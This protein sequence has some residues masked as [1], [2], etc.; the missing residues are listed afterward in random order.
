[1]PLPATAD[2]QLLHR[3]TVICRGYERADGQIEIDAVITDIKTE[4]SGVAERKVPAGE[5]VHAMAL[6][7]TIGEGLI[8]SDA[9]AV[10]DHAPF[11]I[12]PAIAPSFAKLIG[13]RLIKGFSQTVRTMFGGVHGCVHLVDLIGPAATTA[14]QTLGR[15]WRTKAAEA[16]NNKNTAETESKE[17]VV[18]PA[19]INTCHVWSTDSAV[20]KREFP[21]L[22][23]GK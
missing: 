3:R 6:R 18:R 13:V 23:T 5:P 7:L 8:I 16:A 4:A 21:K 12:C 20:V 1:M 10:T 14:Y 11:P 17:K 22:Y 2:R 9:V 15:K 19:F